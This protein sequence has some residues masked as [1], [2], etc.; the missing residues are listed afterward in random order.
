MEQLSQCG[1]RG[2]GNEAALV[3]VSG[4]NAETGEYDFVVVDSKQENADV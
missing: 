4:K 3:C 2:I 1:T